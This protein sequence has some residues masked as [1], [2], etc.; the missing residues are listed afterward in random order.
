MYVYMCIY[1]YM[2]VYAYVDVDVYTYLRVYLYLYI[3]IYVYMHLITRSQV[4]RLD[5][6]PRAHLDT[7]T[8]AMIA[9]GVHEILSFAREQTG[10]NVFRTHLQETCFVLTETS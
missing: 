1:M 4:T 7:H 8:R 3:Y 10:E 9:I 2:C 5:I 6:T